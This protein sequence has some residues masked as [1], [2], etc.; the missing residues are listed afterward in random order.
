MNAYQFAHTIIDKLN[1]TNVSTMTLFCSDKSYQTPYGYRLLPMKVRI[2][3]HGCKDKMDLGFNKL[4]GLFKEVPYVKT[5]KPVF[6]H[7]FCKYH[8]IT[9]EKQF[10]EHVYFDHEL[11]WYT[12]DKD[13][14]LPK[15]ASLKDKVYARIKEFRSVEIAD[16]EDFDEL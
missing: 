5:S 6:P 4:L 9:K 12:D 15:L 16:E 3:Q 1:L 2:L 8:I 14:L 13:P 7:L 10:N 11:E